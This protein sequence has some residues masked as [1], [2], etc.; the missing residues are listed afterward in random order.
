MLM[1]KL[2]RMLMNQTSLVPNEV[3]PLVD[4]L[5]LGYVSRLPIM[6]A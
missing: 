4:L 6:P 1:V 5:V 3:N 2:C